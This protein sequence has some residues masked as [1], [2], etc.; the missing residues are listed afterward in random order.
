MESINKA[1]LKILKTECFALKD[2]H[3]ILLY[4]SSLIHI[5][6]HREG[7]LKQNIRNTWWFQ[8]RKTCCEVIMSL[9]LILLLLFFL[10]STLSFEPRNPEGIFTHFIHIFLNFSLTIFIFFLSIS[11]SSYCNKAR[12]EWSAW[13]SHQ[14]GWRLRRSLQLVH[15]YLQFRQPRHCPVRLRFYPLPLSF[16]SF[17][18]NFDSMCVFCRG[19]PSQGLSGSLSWMIANLTNLKQV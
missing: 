3:F 12:S 7:E 18:I 4:Y 10:T 17:N 15:D 8:W 5:Y 14:L 13:S 6:T 1:R 9:S 19:A 11:W 16:S 2:A